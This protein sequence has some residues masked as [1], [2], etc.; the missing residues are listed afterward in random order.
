M[1]GLSRSAYTVRCV[2]GMINNCGIL[3]RRDD[4]GN[5][6]DQKNNG[7]D[8]NDQE[9]SLC[10]EVYRIYRSHD[11]VDHPEAL[12]S[13]ASKRRASYD[14]TTPVK[15]MGLFDTVGGLGIPYL[16]PGIGL[17][18]NEFH[19]TKVSA[20][21]YHALSIHDRLW[22]FEPCYAL[23]AKHRIES[24]FEIHESWFPGCH[25]DLGRREFSMKDC[26]STIIPRIEEKIKELATRIKETAT[27][28]GSGDVY[29]NLFPYGPLGNQW[30][31]LDNTIVKSVLDSGSDTSDFMEYVN[32]ISN[33]LWNLARF[34]FHVGG[35]VLRKT[36]L[37]NLLFMNAAI[38]AASTLS[39]LNPF[40]ERTSDMWNSLNMVIP[41]PVPQIQEHYRRI[42]PDKRLKDR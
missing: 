8:L 13:I 40:S 32:P 22:I 38:I 24:K 5:L 3:R 25:Y 2:A 27:D 16:N 17:T 41:V 19:D 26:G 31:P 12:R 34:N 4:N 33:I 6:L 20:V 1:F 18:F 29:S 7:D 11:P 10:K 15:F 42:G 39:R 30:E 36:H 28:R 35:I 21:V 14:V 23:P 37:N 9:R